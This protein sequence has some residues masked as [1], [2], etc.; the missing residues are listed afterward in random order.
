MGKGENQLRSW[1]S[2][3]SSDP[4]DHSSTT[5]PS[6]TCLL[7]DSRREFGRPEIL[8][9]W[10]VRLWAAWS[11]V[12]VNPNIPQACRA[13]PLHPGPAGKGHRAVIWAGALWGFCEHSPLGNRGSSLLPT[14]PWCYLLRSQGAGLRT[15]P[16]S[17]PPPSSDQ[18]QP[19]LQ[20]RFKGQENLH[21]LMAGAV[22]SH[23]KTGGFSRRGITI[24]IWWSSSDSGWVF[25]ED[26]KNHYRTRVSVWSF[27]MTGGTV[28]R[29][30]HLG[31]VGTDFPGKCWK[32]IIQ[33]LVFLFFWSQVTS[34]CS[35]IQVTSPLFVQLIF[36]WIC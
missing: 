6:C 20:P 26:K 8:R 14:N 11:L 16:A 36:F 19:Q 9:V 5:R 15:S 4:K 10:K 3:P 17:L 12:A 27:K 35:Y 1:A 13:E 29:R 24:F 30:C 33:S 18:S 2:L 31:Q 7:L 28:K 22:E 32:S 23:D 34:S 21:L 25:H